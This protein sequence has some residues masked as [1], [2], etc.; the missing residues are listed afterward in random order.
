MDTGDQQTSAFNSLGSSGEL[1]AEDFDLVADKETGKVWILHGKP[2]L[3]QET[4]VR[5]EYSQSDHSLKFVSHDGAIQRLGPKVQA[6]LQPFFAKA[7][8]I[9]GIHTDGNGA[10]L[11]LFVVPI[12]V[13][14]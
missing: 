6:Q 11:G 7:P 2:F 9:T 4:V 10:V 12:I 3:N 13:K 14:P 1:A 8:E 5:A